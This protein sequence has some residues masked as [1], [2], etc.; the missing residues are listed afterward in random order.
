MLGSLKALTAV[1]FAEATSWIGLLIA[2]V[3]KYG[4]DNE[5]GV[6]VMGPIHGSL[7]LAFVVLLAVVHVQRNWSITRTAISFA[8]SIPPVLGFVL[9]K[10]LLDELKRDEHVT[11]VKHT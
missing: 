2:M 11:G 4:F 8:E 9:G 6:Q 7:F 10:H 1:T 3:F 5:R